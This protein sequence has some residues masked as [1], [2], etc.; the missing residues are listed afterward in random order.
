MR[1]IGRLGL[2]A[3]V[4]VMIGASPVQ[5]AEQTVA[6]SPTSRVLGTG[7]G[8]LTCVPTL[9]AAVAGN[10]TF[11]FTTT[12][13]DG[14]RGWRTLTLPN[15]PAL[16]SV[17]CPTATFCAAVSSGVQDRE[18][19]LRTVSLW[20]SAQ[21][22]NASSWRELT[23]PV[24]TFG[25]GS[26]VACPTVGDCV[27]I[28]YDTVLRAQGVL[29][30]ASWTATAMPGDG[31]NDVACTPDTCV[32]GSESGTLA[33]TATSGGTWTVTG[34]LGD[35][36]TSVWCGFGR[37]GAGLQSKGVRLGDPRSPLT[38][39]SS[40]TGGYPGAALACDQDATLCVSGAYQGST[41]IGPGSA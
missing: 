17:S 29:G 36:A 7:S 30:E 13:A 1:R 33:T 34:S 25:D 37:C 14:A 22:T 12:P 24:P 41:W 39:T 10:G 4:L 18:K 35:K 11:A 16:N 3:I 8:Q 40:S 19:G 21:P 15:A 32:A 2:V 6:I 20:V 38:W 27:V 28:G 9:C 31:W 5:A 26:R 23:A